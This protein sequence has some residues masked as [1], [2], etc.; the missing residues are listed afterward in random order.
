MN[1]EE[2]WKPPPKHLNLNRYEVSS[3][4]RIRNKETAYIFQ[5]APRKTTGYVNSN[6]ILDSGNKI[7]MFHHR[8]IA[9]T[10]LP[11]PENFEIVD[12][13][14][15]ICSDNRVKN[16]RWCSPKT[17]SS[18]KHVEKKK[19]Y[20]KVIEQLDAKDNVLNTWHETC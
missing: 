5:R 13:I 16:L 4:G 3:L 15:G 6:L 2:I 18:N 17:N 12:H 19:V 9:F 7:M 1:P 11:N 10:F 8:L 14:N 20:H